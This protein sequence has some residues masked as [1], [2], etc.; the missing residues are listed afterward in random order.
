MTS[1]SANTFAMQGSI[2]EQTPEQKLFER[3]FAHAYAWFRGNSSIQFDAHSEPVNIGFLERFESL[4]PGSEFRRYREH[5]VSHVG[6]IT[7]HLGRF[8]KVHELD[9]CFC[10]LVEALEKYNQLS[11]E[12]TP[13]AK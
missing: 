5:L 8:P 6:L 11:G 12:T 13:S 3:Y 1:Q 7:A 10:E 4:I 9:D 2:S